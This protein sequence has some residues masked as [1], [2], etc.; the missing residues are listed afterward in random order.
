MV[1]IQLDISR[2]DINE[3]ATDFFKTATI[4]LI[5]HILSSTIDNKGDLLNEK[6]LKK[7]LY[8]VIAMVFYSVFIKKFLLSKFL[9]VN[10]KNK[11]K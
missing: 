8:S 9:K 5:V 3:F 4:I 1:N 2:N 10:V 11:K 7:L 6:V